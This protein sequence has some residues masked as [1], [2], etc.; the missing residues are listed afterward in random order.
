MNDTVRRWAP[1]LLQ[2]GGLV[3]TGTLFVRGLDFASLEGALVRPGAVGWFGLAFVLYA[4]GMLANGLAWRGLLASA[5]SRIPTGEM[6]RHDLSSTFWSS[7]LPGGMAGELVKGVRLSRTAD[8]GAVAVAIVASRLVSGSASCVL[9][10]VLLPWSA[11]TG[12]P[13]VAGALVLAAVATVGVAGLVVL[14]LGPAVLA[15]VAVFAPIAARIPVG[16]FPPPRALGAAFV[17]TFLGH[18]AFAGYCSAAFAAAGRWIP[19]ADGAT[20]LSLTSLAELPPITIGGYGVREL[21]LSRLGELIV[22]ETVAEAGAVAFSLVATAMV[23]IGGIVELGRVR[24]SEG[25]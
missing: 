7:V 25:A 16:R 18:A 10:I 19:L 21:T 1:R 3:V 4:A 5:G 9:A 15:R 20:F 2:V 17:Q 22:P 23:L 11:L 24:S 6:V 12:A 8:A 14:R 13:R